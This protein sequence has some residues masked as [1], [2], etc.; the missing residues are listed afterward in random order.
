MIQEQDILYSVQAIHDA[1]NAVHNAQQKLKVLGANPDLT[2]TNIEELNLYEIRAPFDGVIVDKHIGLG[3]AV[4]AD[5]KIFTISDLSSIWAEFSVSAKDLN[6]LRIGD[7]A[8]IEA[9]D[10]GAKITG[11]VSYLGQLIGEKSQT[12]IARVQIENPKMA[13]RTGLKVNIQILADK[14]NSPIAVNSTAVSL[15]NGEPSVFVRTPD[16]FIAQPVVTGRSDNSFIEIDKGLDP[17]TEY[18]TDAETLINF[19]ADE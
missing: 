11:K 5:D 14:A 19:Q 16:G 9:I 13:W 3:V 15:I 12:A 7:Q 10:S 18:A 2:S 6:N 8:K 4:K 1:E 17:G